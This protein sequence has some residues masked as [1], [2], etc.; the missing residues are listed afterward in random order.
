MRKILCAVLA[1]VVC[2]VFVGV[3][4]ADDGVVVGAEK[5]KLT[6]K[7]GDKEQVVEMKG[8]KVVGADGKELK[9]KAAM[10]ALKKDAKV[11]VT[12][13]GET[14]TITIKK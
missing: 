6:V 2:L 10:E 9:G 1:M 7:V 5:G 13:E 4:N 3:M 12:K 11:S 14:T 8:A